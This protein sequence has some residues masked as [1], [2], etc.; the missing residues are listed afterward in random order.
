MARTTRPDRHRRAQ[1]HRRPWEGC[2]SCC[3]AP[4]QLN[5]EVSLTLLKENGDSGVEKEVALKVMPKKKVKGNEESVWGE[6]EVLK[7]LDHPNI[8]SGGFLF[9]FFLTNAQS[10]SRLNSTNGSNLAQNIIFHSSSPSEG[11]C[12]SGYCR[13]G[14]LLK[15]MQLL[16]LGRRFAVSVR[17]P[18][19]IIVRSILAGVKYLHDHDIVHRDLKYVHFPQAHAYA[20]KLMLSFPGRKIFS[21]G[22]RRGTVILSLRILA[23]ASTH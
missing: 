13:R 16:W 17:E 20:P 3:V 22:Q 9:Y 6:M 7:G 8:V 12:S 5:H 23:C 18:D 11:S 2:R 1:G 14:S 19:L 21:I 4:T 15:R 10:F